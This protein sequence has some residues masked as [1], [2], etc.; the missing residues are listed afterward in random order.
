LLL[1]LAHAARADFAAAA[2]EFRRAA[3]LDPASVEAWN[4]LGA[5]LEKLGDAAGAI[6]AYERALKA[7]PQFEKA[8]RN[9]ERL[10]LVR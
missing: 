10:R 7:N 3:D 8:R 9:L 2:K 1:G 4:N 6:D 5:A